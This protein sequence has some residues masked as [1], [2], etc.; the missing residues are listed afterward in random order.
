M[1]KKWE[2]LQN[3]FDVEFLKEIEMKVFAYNEVGEKTVVMSPLDSIKY[4]AKI[5][6][7]G[8]LAVNPHNGFIKAWVGGV[9]YRYFKFDHVE[10]RRQI[11]STI[12]PFVY[13]TAISLQGISPCDAFDDIQYS[14]TPGESNFELDEEWS[15]SNA[16]N[17]FTGNK[18]NLFQGLLYSK[19][20]ITIRLVKEMGSVE[21]IRKLL[22]NVG[23]NVDEKLYNGQKLVPNLPSICLGAIDL[24]VKE[25]VGA[26]TTFANEGV[27][28]K[29]NM[30]Q[31]IVDK[32]GSIIYEYKPTSIQALNTLHNSLMV[33]MLRNN[34]GGRYGLGV[35]SQIGGKTGTT[36][37]FNDGWFMSITPDLVTGV[38]VG[39]D[40]KWI[41]FLSLDDGQGYVIARPIVQKFIQKLEKDENCSFNKNG[42]FVAPPSKFGAYTDC[43]KYK[44]VTPEDEIKTRIESKKDDDD[45]ED[46]FDFEGETDQSKK[47]FIRKG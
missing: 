37:D 5:L 13:A 9:D 11:G 27:Y 4:H 3:A 8:L 10:S 25:M 18:Y 47:K 31:R 46:E 23:I 41:R 22:N 35:S 12:K 39:G 36:N 40:D 45:M 29:P 42:K 20:S 43:D 6:Q 17:I 30:V 44:S 33:D 32:K 24:S 16:N 34:V 26:Y 19:N 28:V 2:A 38:W 14:I 15:P 1:R 21:V 7:A